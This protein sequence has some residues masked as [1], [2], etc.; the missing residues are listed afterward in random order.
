VVKEVGWFTCGLLRI[1]GFFLLLLFSSCE[2]GTTELAVLVSWDE[3]F[4]KWQYWRYFGV[5]L[6]SGL[7]E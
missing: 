2:V 6:W 5:A 1:C 4:S 3:T 7:T